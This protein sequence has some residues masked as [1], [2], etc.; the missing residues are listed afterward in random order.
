MKLMTQSNSSS[1]ETTTINNMDLEDT[2]KQLTELNLNEKKNAVLFED[3]SVSIPAGL[4]LH[5]VDDKLV[6]SFTSVPAHPSDPLMF[7]RTVKMYTTLL[8]AVLVMNVCFCSFCLTS[9]FKCIY[10]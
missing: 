4:Q 7:S 3:S 6:L 5:T 10:S 8:A 9:S 2:E 1:S